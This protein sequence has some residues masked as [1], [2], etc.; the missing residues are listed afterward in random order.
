MAAEFLLFT[1]LR[2]QV[3]ASAAIVGVILVRGATRRRLGPVLGYRLWWAVPIAV[4]ASLMPGFAEWLNGG[5]VHVTGSTP[6]PSRLAALSALDFWRPHAGALAAGWSAGAACV[7]TLFLAGE[8]RI[9]R[10]AALG[11]A[12]PAVI[13]VAAPRLVVPTDFRTRFDDRER[14]LIR[15][16]ERTH[17]EQGHPLANLV[18]AILQVAGWF[19]PLTHVAAVLCRFDQ[20]LACDALVL[21]SR[22]KD[23]KAYAQAL[24]RAHTG[25]P[26]TARFSLASGWVASVRHPLE[27]R[28]RALSHRPLGLREHVSG[29]LTIALG[30]AALAVA[31]WAVNPNPQVTGAAGFM[32]GGRPQA[33]RRAGPS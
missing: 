19:N 22:W 15:L 26:S 11:V 12:G 17:I 21:E 28:L 25:A 3:A 31:I 32:Q 4:A 10:H 2:A 13:G 7:C 9:R 1:L 6:V 5:V 30:G 18:I 33:S 29:A 23:R 27:T 24:L 16:H 20:E 8:V 14:A